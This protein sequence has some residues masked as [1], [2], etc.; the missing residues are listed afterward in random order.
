[1]SS[2]SRMHVSREQQISGNELVKGV[3]NTV[4]KKTIF[5]VTPHYN[6][7][8]SRYKYNTNNSKHKLQCDINDDNKTY[9]YSSNKNTTNLKIMHVIQN[10]I[11]RYLSDL[12]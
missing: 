4:D 6:G 3:F 11:L 1:M 2:D 12:T 8:K 7:Y 9:S 10:T 5:F